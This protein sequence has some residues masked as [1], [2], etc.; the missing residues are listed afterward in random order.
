[1]ISEFIKMIFK[2]IILN[3]MA[4]IGI[5]CGYY[6]M[7]NNGMDYI[8]QIMGDPQTYLPQTLGVLWLIALFYA[9]L[10]RPVYHID[11]DKIN[12]KKTFGSSFE[13]L[14]IMACAA[15]ITCIIINTA[16]IDLSTKFDRYARN[17]KTQDDLSEVI[18]QQQ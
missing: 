8:H 14:T 5:A 10:F 1:M 2:V 13:H 15:F 18:N 6:I 16:N 4:L 17:I 3:P 11:S 9:I 7:A 12:W